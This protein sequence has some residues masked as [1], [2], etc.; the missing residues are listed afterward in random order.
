[1]PGFAGRRKMRPMQT[2]RKRLSFLVA[3]VD[4][5][6]VEIEKGGRQDEVV[7][8]ANQVRADPAPVRAISDEEWRRLLP[9]EREE[10]LPVYYLTLRSELVELERDGKSQPAGARAKW[11]EGSAPKAVGLLAG[12]GSL[13]ELGIHALHA[14][15]VLAH[16]NEPDR[17]DPLV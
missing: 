6:A 11:L 1:M 12:I 14:A 10:A 15:G 7:K 16:E 8:L 9:A 17:S 5:L 4:R 13:I 2:R 3:E